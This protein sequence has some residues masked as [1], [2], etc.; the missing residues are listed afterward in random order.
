MKA[1]STGAVRLSEG[2][3]HSAACRVPQALGPKE[4]S[5]VEIY[6]ETF[7]KDL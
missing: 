3:D 2:G 6:L 4:Q 1:Q 5:R 7:V